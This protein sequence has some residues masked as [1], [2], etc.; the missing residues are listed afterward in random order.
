MACVVGMVCLSGTGLQAQSAETWNA[1][2]AADFSA[3]CIGTAP[4]FGGFESVAG[5]IGLTRNERGFT[6][7]DDVEATLVDESQ[8]CTCSMTMGAPD[9]DG[10][11]DAIFQRI[12]GDY[13][14]AY[15][16]NPED[17]RASFYL[18]DEILVRVEIVTEGAEGDV[19]MI[20]SARTNLACAA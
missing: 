11:A 17:R 18:R 7:G 13:P 9:P 4:T 3:L 10:L 20:A 5:Q 1:D 2:R 12:A 8:S 16:D 14:G 15:F 19:R 6:L